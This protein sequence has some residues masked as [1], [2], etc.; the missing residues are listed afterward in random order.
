MFSIVFGVFMNIMHSLSSSA[1]IPTS[2]LLLPSCVEQKI[3]SF[4]FSYRDFVSATTLSGGVFFSEI[5]F[6]YCTPQA[7]WRFMGVSVN[8][9]EQTVRGV[10]LEE[11]ASSIFRSEPTEDIDPPWGCIFAFCET[12]LCSKM[13][14]VVSPFVHLKKDVH[15]PDS[16][17]VPICSFDYQTM[18]WSNEVSPFSIPA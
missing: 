14:R 16:I 1:H 9:I 10:H 7:S 11:L 2:A 17:L 15:S 12:A 4:G 3:S 6:L 18:T 8:Y 13:G 5:A